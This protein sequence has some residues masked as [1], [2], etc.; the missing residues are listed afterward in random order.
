MHTS[1]E[2]LGSLENMSIKFIRPEIWS[3]NSPDLNPLYNFLC[4]EIENRLVIMKIK[5][6]LELIQKLKNVLET[7]H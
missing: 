3:A 4:N 5:I 6:K 1:S 2:M 7:L